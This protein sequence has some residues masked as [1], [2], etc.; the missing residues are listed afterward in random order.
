MSCSKPLPPFTYELLC[1]LN[2]DQLERFSIVC[3]PLKN[4]IDRY[5]HSK[6][7]RVFDQLYIRGGSYALRHNNV[8]WHP[9]RDDYSA[10]QFLDGQKCRS[11]HHTY[12]SFAEMRPYLGPSVRV[13]FTYLNVAGNS[14]YNS[15]H[16]EEMESIAYLWRDGKICIWNAKSDGSRIVDNDFQLILNSPT[17]LQCRDLYME[18]AHFSFKDY[19]VLY[20]VKVIEV[21]YN[22][23]DEE[24][25]DLNS[26]PEFLEQPGVKP[27]VVLHYYHRENIAFI[28]DRLSQPFSSA[29]L[30]NGFKV[31]FSQRNE[32]LEPLTQFRETNKTLGEILELKKV[33]PTEY[34]PEHLKGH[35]CYTLERSRV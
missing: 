3:R 30:P 17:I 12:Y 6:P 13:Q 9:N 31:V 29:V 35:E 2:R 14:T 25:I 33:L 23:K 1:Y 26:W 28:I 19:K 21:Y 8:F 5:F 20:S 10:Q 34:Q 22:E 18:N 27:V 16:I 24:E 11:S 32:P 7:Y 15:Q 4:F